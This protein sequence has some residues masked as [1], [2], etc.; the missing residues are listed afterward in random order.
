MSD[1]AYVADQAR[2]AFSSVARLE[3][4]LRQH[5]DRV[6]LQINLAAEK[7]RARKAD[8]HMR[9][10]AEY[11]QIEICDYKLLPEIKDAFP[12]SIISRSL[13]NY[14]GLFT[15]I[16][17][18]VKNGVQKAKSTFGAQALSESELE[19]GYSYEGSLGVV[20][21]TR[22]DRNF[23]EGKLDK[24]IEALYQTMNIDDQHDVR[25]VA[26]ALGGSVIKRLHDWSAANVAGGYS[27]DV[28][29]KLS[30]GR[31]LGQVVPRRKMVD[32]VEIIE[33]TSDQKSDTFET[34]GMLAG[35]DVISSRFHFV[36]SNG[37]SYKGNLD[38]NFD[39][40]R[41]L[42]LGEMYVAIIKRTSKEFY[43]TQRVEN[44]YDLL[45]LK[46]VTTNPSAS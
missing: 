40:Y 1:Y 15:Q 27:A 8:A 5:P 25:D 11:N 30:S 23:F 24:S 33:R 2:R 32:I 28:R 39:K 46:P 18:S 19:F 38:Q 26:R 17:D 45:D 6:D 44:T 29:W 7:K 43:A 20:L 42:K 16:H 34:I 4:A 21:M 13:L 9:Q 41:T 37:E 3:S 12:I 31:L 10:L 22:A 36:E 14:Q 35:G